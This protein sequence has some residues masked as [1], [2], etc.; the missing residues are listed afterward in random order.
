MD[1]FL[2][3][4]RNMIYF[5]AD[6][7]AKLDEVQSPRFVY[8]HLLLPHVPFMFD[9]NGN[10][11]DQQYRN[12]WNYYLGNYIFT[13]QI[14]E[15]IVNNLM[16]AADP[17][18]PPIIILQSDHGARNQI[19]QDNESTLLKN[20]PEE[21][22]SNILFALYMPGYDTSTIPQNVNPNNTFPIIFNYLFND[23]IPLQ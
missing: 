15:K 14:A 3:N 8:V 9:A 1:P 2:K 11:V 22:K 6:K 16:A 20:F 21:Y 17:K 12:N 7:V 10:V 5:T 23:N 18:R 19:I 13:I 4:H